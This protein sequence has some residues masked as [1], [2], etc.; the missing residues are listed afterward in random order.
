MIIG[1]AS[2]YKHRDSCMADLKYMV[3]QKYCGI[4]KVW[5]PWENQICG[6][7]GCLSLSSMK[8]I[9]L[10]WFLIIFFR[11][12]DLWVQM[13]SFVPMCW[14]W[15]I[16]DSLALRRQ[17]SITRRPQNCWGGLCGEVLADDSLI[18]PTSS[19]IHGQ[20]VGRKGSNLCKQQ[21]CYLTAKPSRT[22]RMGTLLSKSVLCQRHF[23]EQRL[24]AVPTHP[25]VKLCLKLW[26]I[27]AGWTPA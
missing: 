22:P 25:P 15:M 12:F 13:M 6:Y 19:N 27:W 24:K 17:S 21:Q 23:A 26:K 2:S 7:S 5:V 3:A 20:Q 8:Y 4:P 14:L 16:A 11:Y 18:T 10:H 9:F 1:L